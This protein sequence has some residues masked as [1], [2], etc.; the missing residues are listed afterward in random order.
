MGKDKG[1]RLVEDE[2]WRGGEKEEGGLTAWRESRREE[3]G[4]GGEE[5]M[6][7]MNG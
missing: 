1:G 3:E 5:R 2:G 4:G 7:G 6:E